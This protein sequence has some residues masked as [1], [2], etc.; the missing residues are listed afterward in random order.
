MKVNY[1]GYSKETLQRYYTVINDFELVDFPTM[2]QPID[3]IKFSFNI[4]GPERKFGWQGYR[5][6][7]FGKS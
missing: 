5:R 4:I 1:T 3:H 6:K 7:Y 2:S